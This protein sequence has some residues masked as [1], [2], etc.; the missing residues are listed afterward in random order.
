MKEIKFNTAKKIIKTISIIHRESISESCQHFVSVSGTLMLSL[1][2]RY[3]NKWYE[4]KRVL[5]SPI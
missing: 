3:R 5:Q 1:H 2:L 4:A